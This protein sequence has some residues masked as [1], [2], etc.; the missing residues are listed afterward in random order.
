MNGKGVFHMG[1]FAKYAAAFFKM[2]FSI[3]TTPAQNH[4]ML[5]SFFAVSLQIISCIP[6]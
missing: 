4:R 5:F 1:L 3:R 6:P 2:S